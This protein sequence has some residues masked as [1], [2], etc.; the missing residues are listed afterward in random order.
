MQIFMGK[1]TELQANAA[2]FSFLLKS[3]F[4]FQFNFTQTSRGAVAV[5]VQND[6]AILV[7][8]SSA[9]IFSESEGG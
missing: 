3:H 1:Y 7:Y 9:V 5:V 4:A 8:L 2:F 6:V